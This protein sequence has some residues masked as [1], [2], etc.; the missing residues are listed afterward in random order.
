MVDPLPQLE[1]LAVERGT[2]VLL[3][4]DFNVPLR[5]G[6]IED[7]LRI[8]AALPTIEYLRKRGAEVVCCS[9][10]GRPKGKFDPQCSLAPV[11]ARLS[12]LLGIVVAL[13]P[14]VAGFESLRRAQSLEPG[15]VMLI[16]NLRF[17]PGEEANDPAFAA[18]LSE[19]GDVY[20]DDAFGAA[21]RAHASIVGPPLVLPA[22]AGRL[23]AREV[24]VLGGLLAAPKRPFVAILGGAKVSDKLGVIDALLQ[25]CETLLVGGAMAF[26]FLAAR[27]AQV[28]DSLVQDD[29]VEHCR[30]LLRSG[31]IEIPTDVVAAAEMTASARTRH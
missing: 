20:V 5:D 22:A 14:E 18:N 7:D 19:L 12:E 17:D 24:E 15:T 29:Q 16:E 11:A 25:R 21:H 3:R 31:R 30:E 13:S 1:D 23:L 27:G 9:H 26:T 6:R 10:L 8:T 28:G 2:R 4:A